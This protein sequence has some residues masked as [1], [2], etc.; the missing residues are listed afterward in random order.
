MA[1][2]STKLKTLID[3]KK[4]TDFQ[5]IIEEFH[6]SPHRHDVTSLQKMANLISFIFGNEQSITVEE[7]RKM[8]TSFVQAIE[9]MTIVQ[10]DETSSKKVLT[11]CFHVIKR[12]CKDICTE[13]ICHLMPIG[14]KKL[15][16]IKMYLEIV[17]PFAITYV[18]KILIYIS[19]GIF[20]KVHITIYSTLNLNF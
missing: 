20:S 9:S 6:Q 13:N 18:P 16:Q 11:S 1:L 15:C 19:M 4:W 17:A 5:N 14:K 10:I 2:S 7:L 12:L 8:S 3:N